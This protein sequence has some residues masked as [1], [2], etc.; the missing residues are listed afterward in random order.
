MASLSKAVP[1]A[2]AIPVAH[3]SPS[4]T[5]VW[6]GTDAQAK[7]VATKLS[8]VRKDFSLS[9]LLHR[10]ESRKI[11]TQGEHQG[12]QVGGAWIPETLCVEEGQLQWVLV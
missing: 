10:A 4:C 12:C 5:Q 6:Q 8:I 7:D 9:F 2:S 3:L 1:L 11:Q